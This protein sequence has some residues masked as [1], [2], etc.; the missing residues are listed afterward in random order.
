[1]PQERKHTKPQE[2]VKPFELREFFVD[3]VRSFVPSAYAQLAA[4]PASRAA[5]Y[6]G[7]IA[8][9]VTLLLTPLVY[10]HQERWRSVRRDHYARVLP[11]ELYFEEGKAKYDSEQPYVHVE[12]VGGKR[13]AYIVDTTGETTEIPAEYDSGMLV[14]PDTIIRKMLTGPE[15]TE[16]VDGPIPETDGRIRAKAYFLNAIDKERVP[17]L[18]NVVGFMFVMTV[19]PLFVLATLVA[20]VGAAIEATRKEARVPFRAC[21]A[22]AAHAA[23]PVAFIAASGFAVE[24]DVQRYLVFGI[25]LLA[26]TL[27]MTLGLQTYRRSIE[28]GRAT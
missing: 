6:L 20:G 4:R 8:F 24:T 14:T 16:T 2:H 18:M 1:M 25:P 12:T 13:D 22:I 17:D 10:M 15:R 19:V 21:F 7:G 11:D 3:L 26:F 5:L 9:L 28:A 23:T 27:L